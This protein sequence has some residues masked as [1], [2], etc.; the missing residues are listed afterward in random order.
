MA[1]NEHTPKDFFFKNSY[2]KLGIILESK[3]VQKL[4]LEKNVFTKKWS[5]KSS[6]IDF[7]TTILAL[8]DDI[9]YKSRLT[10]KKCHK[11]PDGIFSIYGRNGITP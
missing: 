11:K 9:T 10:P 5:P 4:S 2:E 6:K 8:F 3:M 1:K 7:E